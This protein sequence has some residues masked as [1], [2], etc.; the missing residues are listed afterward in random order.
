M[1]HVTLTLFAL[2]AIMFCIGCEVTPESVTDVNQRIEDRY[3]SFSSVEYKLTEL[4]YR[5]GELV[6]K[7]EYTEF[8]KKPDKRKQ[9]CK[10]ETNG[11]VENAYWICNGNTSYAINRSLKLPDTTLPTTA[12]IYE[13]INLPPEMTTF[14]GYYID[15]GVER[16]K[17]PAEI[18]DKTKYKVETSQVSYNGANAIK[19]VVTVLMSE[20]AKQQQVAIG[21]TPRETVVIYWFD[22]D[23]L[24]ILK[25]E[26][27]SFGTKGEAEPVSVTG[28]DEK[29][30]IQ[31]QKEIEI[32]AETVYEWFRFDVDIPDSEFE[33]NPLDY[34]GI[35]FKKTVVDTQEKFK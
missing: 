33:V 2:A 35:E 14:C 21:K 5:N 24:T 27:H 25:E 1:K 3:N 6:Q 20:E 10:V 8:I 23:N 17:I 31:N 34:P 12:D 26:S 29:G 22:S 7:S 15:K 30:K 4:L 9:V 19:A 18:T 32:K 28:S 16:W 13:Y 11:M